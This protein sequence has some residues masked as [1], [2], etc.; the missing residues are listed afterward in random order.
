M[1]RII[2]LVLLHCLWIQNIL[3][4]ENIC[5]IVENISMCEIDTTRQ[6]ICYEFGFNKSATVCIVESDTLCDVY[7]SGINSD[8]FSTTTCETEPIL[9]WAFGDLPKELMSA[10]F[11]EDNEYTPFFYQLILYDGRR[12]LTIDS[13]SK[14]VDGNGELSD[15]IDALK[16]FMAKL[17][18]TWNFDDS[19]KE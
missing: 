18:V 14:H 1:K 8:D 13:S 3:S 10:Q 12:R 9:K 5:V 17:W 19:I 16:Q 6:Y 2:S 7:V 4:K 11:A 15:K